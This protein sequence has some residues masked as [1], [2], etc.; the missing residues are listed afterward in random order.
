MDFFRRLIG[1]NRS[2]EP[3]AGSTG[4][5]GKTGK[6]DPLHIDALNN[7]PAPVIT[8]PNAVVSSELPTLSIQ[9]PA[10]GDVVEIDSSPTPL[11][12][13]AFGGTRPL[14]PI[15]T[16][17]SKPGK[18]LI[19]GLNS[20]IGRQRSNNQ[21]LMLTFF[22]A[23]VSVEERPDFGLF[24]VADGMG[25]HHDGEKASAITIRIVTQYIIDKLYLNLLTAASSDAD[26]PTIAEMLSD[27]I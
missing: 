6:L 15:E 18:H 16:Y 20:D 4:K 3:A 25:G 5:N 14:P 12:A 7:A 1:T 17:V 26:R 19:Y 22:T 11:N 13:S 24:A 23:N 21:D 10:A 9:A 2:N 27:A 8:A